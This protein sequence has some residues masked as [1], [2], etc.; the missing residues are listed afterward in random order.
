MGYVILQLALTLDG[1]IARTDGTV[2]FLENS[3]DGFQT[4]FDD[5]VSSI[6]S[7][8][9]GRKTYNQMLTFGDIPFK[10][11]EI[12]VLTHNV[13]TLAEPHIHFTN[14]DLESLLNKLSGNIWL[15]GGSQVITQCLE[16]DLIEEYQL[17]IVPHLIG[18]GIRLFEPRKNGTA[19]QLHRTKQYGDNVLLIYKQ[20]KE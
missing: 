19:L 1:Y 10:D 5:F 18:D 16:Q 12:Y 3:M 15:F 9:M 20:C 7:I 6:D 11:K 17:F 13:D 14:Q 4:D 2:D 8:V